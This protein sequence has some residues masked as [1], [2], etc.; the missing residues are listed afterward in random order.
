VRFIRC[1]QTIDPVRL[2]TGQQCQKVTRKIRMTGP[3]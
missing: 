1:Q 3:G 2:L